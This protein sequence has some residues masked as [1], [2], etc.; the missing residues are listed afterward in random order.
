MNYLT[1]GT[2][3]VLVQ[4][5]ISLRHTKPLLLMSTLTYDIRRRGDNLRFPSFR[6]VWFDRVIH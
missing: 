6:R 2:V 1:D 4:S 3:R 5:E